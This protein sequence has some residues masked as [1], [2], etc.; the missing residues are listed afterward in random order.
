MIALGT[1]RAKTNFHLVIV[2]FTLNAFFFPRVL[3]PATHTVGILGRRNVHIRLPP[4][5]VKFFLKDFVADLGQ[6]RT[7][8]LVKVVVL[9]AVLETKVIR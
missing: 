9:L 8:L 6:L 2:V 3:L 1:C 7:I 5:L 4:V